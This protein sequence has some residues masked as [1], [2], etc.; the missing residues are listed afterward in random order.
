MNLTCP[1]CQGT[2][3]VTSALTERPYHPGYHNA[4]LP[5]PTKMVDTVVAACNEC[6]FIYELTR[7]EQNAYYQE[8]GR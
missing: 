3:T 8:G 1:E 7:D 6:E 2:M 5:L 4:D